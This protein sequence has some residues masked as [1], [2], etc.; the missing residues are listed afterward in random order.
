MINQI[1]LIDRRQHGDSPG[2]ESYSGHSEENVTK[3]K[4]T[5]MI[6]NTVLGNEP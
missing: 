6:I 5:H 1:K 2:P 3:G 4:G